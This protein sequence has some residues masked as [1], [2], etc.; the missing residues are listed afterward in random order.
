MGDNILVMCDCYEP[1]R[2]NQDGTVNPPKPIPTNSR[3]SCAAVMDK[4]KSEE[5][6]WVWGGGC[7]PEE[8]MFVCCPAVGTCRLTLRS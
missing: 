8:S 1:P 2:S 7:A 4:A 5:P 3:A 6:W